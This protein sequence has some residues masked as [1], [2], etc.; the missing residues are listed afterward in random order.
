MGHPPQLSASSYRYG[1]PFG[2]QHLICPRAPPDDRFLNRRDEGLHEVS[3]RVRCCTSRAVRSARSRRGSYFFV[4][5]AF[6]AAAILSFT[7]MLVFNF[8]AQQRQAEQSLTYAQDYL[9]FL[10]ST[11]VRDYRDPVV[12]DLMNGNPVTNPRATLAEQVL[13]YN[14]SGQNDNATRLLEAVAKSIPLSMGINV[15]VEE[16]SPPSSFSLY[17][18]AI[19]GGRSAATSHLVAKSLVYAL[20]DQSTIYGPFV[21]VVEVSS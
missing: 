14:Y 1:S 8:F 4:I 15:S 3:G 10:T 21:M 16:M 9:T 5:D 18:R 11:A 7:L 17:S 2:R 12:T 13:L 6:M 19:S 20:V